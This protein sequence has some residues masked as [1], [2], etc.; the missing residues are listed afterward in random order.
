VTFQDLE[1]A[2]MAVIFALSTQ[3]DCVIV[4]QCNR[5]AHHDAVCLIYIVIWSCL[6]YLFG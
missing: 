6:L 2:M 1:I 3:R 5:V 4:I